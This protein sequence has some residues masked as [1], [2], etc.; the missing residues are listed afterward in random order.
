MNKNNLKIAIL[1]MYR[2]PQ[3]QALIYLDALLKNES[4]K[5]RETEI[6]FRIFNTRYGNEM[7]VPEEF[8]AFIS[9]GG[10][11]NPH[12][13]S[14]SDWEKNYFRFLD[15]MMKQDFKDGR[16][17]FH[18]SICHSFQLLCIHFGIASV[19]KRS[20][21]TRM[22]LFFCRHTDEG[23]NDPLFGPLP[24]PHLIVENRNW[25][26]IAPDENRIK[27][28]GIRVLSRESEDPQSALLALRISPYWVATQYHPE[29]EP[30][31]MKALFHTHAKKEEVVSGYG[32]KKWEEIIRLLD[33]KQPSLQNTYQQLIPDFLH[34]AIQWNSEN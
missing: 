6:H 7:P 20:G 30:E 2:N 27:D 3:A 10:P 23:S 14:G 4:G 21:E 5:F 31:A 16:K 33:E 17:K 18:F 13:G 1:S 22:G 15:Q 11:G 9:T 29:T 24:N 8:D 28:L 26:C 19:K 32:Q 12:D 25:Q 34:S